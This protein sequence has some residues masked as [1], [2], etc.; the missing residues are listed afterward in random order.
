MRKKIYD[1]YSAGKT[2]SEISQDLNIDKRLVSYHLDV[3][4]SQAAEGRQD[5]VLQLLQLQRKELERIKQE[6]QS[7]FE[8]SKSDGNPNPQFLDIQLKVVD[9]IIKLYG[10]DKPTKLAITTKNGDDIAK[11]EQLWERILNI[12]Q[13]KFEQIIE[14]HNNPNNEPNNH[15]IIN[16]TI[17]TPAKP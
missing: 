17:S 9:R 13:F 1:L 14:T 6:A 16:T 3:I 12:T 5:E 4:F 15:H 2:V 10:L 11:P 7:A 8:T